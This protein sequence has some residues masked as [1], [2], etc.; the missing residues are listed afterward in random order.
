MSEKLQENIFL[1]ILTILLNLS[2]DKYF[3]CHFISGHINLSAAIKI[4]WYNFIEKVSDLVDVY[5]LR[6]LSLR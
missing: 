1:N 5:H 3:Y 6:D 4:K 2:S